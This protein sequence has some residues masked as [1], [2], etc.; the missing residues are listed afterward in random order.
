[1]SYQNNQF[2]L[3][4]SIDTLL[5]NVISHLWVNC[6]EWVVKKVNVSL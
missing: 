2:V 5:K 1:M 3:Q 6:G 4:N